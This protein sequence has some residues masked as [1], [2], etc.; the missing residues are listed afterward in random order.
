MTVGLAWA[1]LLKLS[2]ELLLLTAA[3]N[4]CKHRTN[5]I[6]VLSASVLSAGYSAVCL[7]GNEMFLA[8]P[9]WRILLLLLMIVLAFGVKLTS[10]YRGAVYLL[11]NA[12]IGGFTSGF[13]RKE[14]IVLFVG[15]VCVG[16]VCVFASD[17]G[18]LGGVPVELCYGDK[19]LKLLALKDTGNRL[20]DPISGKPVLVIDAD[21][22]C[23]LTGLSAQQLKHP[24]ETLCSGILPGLRLIP[25][26]TIGN[27]SGLLLAIKLKDVKI[28]TWKG[29]SLVAFAPETI[30]NGYEAL[31]GGI[32]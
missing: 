31:A 15:A 25:Y 30:G 9:F 3:D 29:N 28:G 24:A 6:G 19:R 12:A 4:L 10:L 11:M 13:E 2:V 16:I 17:E 32:I 27:A 22:A 5:I 20:R 23:K 18:M 7:L 21:A 8:L 26:K 1:V 14:L